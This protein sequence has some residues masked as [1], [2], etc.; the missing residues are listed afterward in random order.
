MAVSRARLLSS[1]AWLALGAAPAAAQVATA[2][3][4]D[5]N[6]FATGTSVS[7]TGSVTT[8]GGGVLAGGNLF[9]SFTTFNLGQGATATWTAA[10][11]AGVTNL[12]NRVTGGSYST[13]A[14]TIDTTQL[15]HAAF[16]FINP[17]GVLFTGGA[18]LNVPG[19]A[20]IST[21]ANGLTFADG[22]RFS[23]VT[24]NG[25][26]FSMSAPQSFGFLGNQ[27]PIIID[28]VAALT[29]YNL[30]DLSLFASDVAVRNS[31][32]IPHTIT[33]ATTGQWVGQLSLADPF[34]SAPLVG[35]TI[36]NNASIYATAT[37]RGLTS[38]QVATGAFTQV[39][40]ALTSSTFINGDAGDLALA[41]Q[42]AT[43]SGGMLASNT[44]DQV[45]QGDAG[46]VRLNVGSLHVTALGQVSSSTFGAGAA[47]NVTINAGSVTVDTQGS[48]GSDSAGGATGRAGTVQINAGAISLASGAEI[49][50][51]TNG[52][53]DAGS[54][55]VVAD[56]VTIDNASIDSA[57]L[58]GTGRG[59]LVSVQ[60]NQ[61][62]LTNLGG[63]GSFSSSPGA[64]GTV[65]VKA[66][67]LTLTSQGNV[68][69]TS[70]GDGAAGDIAISATTVNATDSFI[71]T[72]S[73]GIGRAG[74]VTVAATTVNLNNSTITSET[75]GS[76]AGGDVTVN[77]STVSVTNNSQIATDTFGSGAAGRVSITADKL[78]VDYASIFS[79]AAPGSTGPGGSVILNLGQLQLANQSVVS[80]DT[81][82]PGGAGSVSVTANG[83]SLTGQSSIESAAREGSSGAA[84]QV[85]I[86]SSALTMDDSLIS[87]STFAPG[88]AGNVLVSSN[89]I[90][91]TN[92]SSIE[93][94]A[95]PGSTGQGGEVQ[96]RADSLSVES[97]SGIL[98]STVSSGDAGQ[99]QISATSIVV[100][101]AQLAS[102]AQNGATGAAGALGIQG[103]TLLVTNGGQI[104]T[105]SENPKTAGGVNIAMTGGVTVSGEGS[106]ISSA[107]TSPRPG[108]AGSILISGAPITLADGGS[109]TTNSV[110]GAAGDIT[111]NLPRNSYVVLEG[112]T[113]PGVITTSSGPGTGG[114]ITLSD[115]VA[116]IS[117]G[118]QILALG[119]ERGANVQLTSD[120][121]IRSADRVNQLSVDGLLVLD[122]QVSDVSAGVTIPDISFLDASSVLRG[123]CPAARQRGASSLLRM[124]PFGPYAAPA[125]E[126]SLHLSDGRLGE[127]SAGCAWVGPSL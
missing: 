59:G 103:A 27:Q 61:I 67:V 105:A 69:S 99:L 122:S 95:G 58:N 57:T 4:P 22:A 46:A 107:N 116:I 43:I 102:R 110:A 84:G 30:V 106:V 54:V 41:A 68:F 34:D 38:V 13:I 12:I 71:S 28:S 113:A 62:T 100:D 83:V 21:A 125:D 127:A 11:P 120:F 66:G 74:V 111:L 53:G 48:I 109:I 94:G 96:I 45:T 72:D 119:Q 93:S 70:L 91:L 82:G 49:S 16:Y 52:P 51:S 24:P 3:T 55:Q 98:T 124:R 121:F 77:A 79:D 36:L 18:F 47:G 114:R 23:A 85:S 101:E 126:G 20:Y 5:T 87:S 97:A 90:G 25:S 35:Q 92:A 31:T 44:G 6:G 78:S 15:P 37:V 104:E 76:G 14:G 33:I 112:A 115:P 1:I 86:H 60:A 8:I 65:Q 7:T 73:A 40:G 80:S 81:F 39:G 2:I 26:S 117:N 10:N 42:T 108:A 29:P 88:A 17:A 89:T 118:G 50:S 56:T 123:Q 64:A 9:H 19:A 32:F 75:N 63:L